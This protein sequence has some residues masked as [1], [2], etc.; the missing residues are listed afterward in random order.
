MGVSKLLVQRA[1]ARHAGIDAK[2]V[3]QRM[4]GWTDGRASIDGA[5]FQRLIAAD[6]DG[7]GAD[8]GQ[9]YPFFLAHALQA[10]PQTLGRLRR[11]AGR[12]EVRRHPRASWCAAPA[13]PGCGRAAKS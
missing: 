6:D 10:D 3:A 11:L 8:A 7:V 4:M 12:V 9:P 2:R 5:R 1:L 13:A